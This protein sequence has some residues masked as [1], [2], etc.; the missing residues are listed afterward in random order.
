[1]CWL[2]NKTKRILIKNKI[3]NRKNNKLICYYNIKDNHFF[4]S[5]SVLT[6]L[7]SKYNLN[8]KELN[9][10]LNPIVEE[11]LNYKNVLYCNNK[12]ILIS[13]LKIIKKI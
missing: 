1:M 8:T 9:L 12:S 6:N 2:K 13:G 5:D 4:I 10:L 11:I 3:S 7:T